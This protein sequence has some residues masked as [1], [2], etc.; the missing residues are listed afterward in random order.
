MYCVDGIPSQAECA[1]TVVQWVEYLAMEH[2]Y[3]S[4]CGNGMVRVE[5]VHTYIDAYM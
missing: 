5:F 1:V 3:G 4:V 2:M